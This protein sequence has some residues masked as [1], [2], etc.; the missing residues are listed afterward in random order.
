MLL[1]SSPTLPSPAARTLPRCGFSFSVSRMTIP[2]AVVSSSSTALTISRSPR[3]L[4]FMSRTSV[5]DCL[6]PTGLALY[7]G[8]G[9]MYGSGPECELQSGR[10]GGSV[11]GVARIEGLGVPLALLDT[12]D[13]D[14]V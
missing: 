12:R 1:P 14:R 8:E 11:V 9:P 4:S 13:R 2:L 3:G 5:K 10:R 6:L 7:Q